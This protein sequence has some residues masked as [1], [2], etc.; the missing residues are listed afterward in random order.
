MVRPPVRSIIHEPKL[1]DY[2][3]VHIGI[4]RFRISGGGKV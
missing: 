2:L 3:S 4:G 1:L